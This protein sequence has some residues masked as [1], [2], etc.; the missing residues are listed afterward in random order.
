MSRALHGLAEVCVRWRW[1]V[2]GVWALI[3]VAHLVVS[4]VTGGPATDDDLSLPGTDSQ[5]ATD[6]LAAK[7]PPQQNGSSPVVFHVAAGRLDDQGANE[8][9]IKAGRKAVLALPSVYSAPNPFKNEKQAGYVS[10]DGRYVF[11]PVLLKESSGSISDELAQRV[12]AAASTPAVDQGIDVAVGGPVGSTLSTPSTEKSE[13]LGL[14][15]AMLIMAVTFG[16]LVAMGM[17][18]IS[19][20]CGLV[21]GLAL[22]GLLAQLTSVPSVGPTIATMIGLGVGIDYALFLVTKHRALLRDGLDVRESIVRA[23]ATSGGAVVF[24]GGTVV[25]ALVSLMVAGIPFVSAL[26]W[27][28]ALAVVTAVLAAIT[29]LPAVL[30]I[31]GNGINRLRLPWVRSTPK[32]TDGSGG[33]QRWARFVTG[34]PLISVIIAVAVLVPLILPVFTLRLGQE[35]IGVT[36]LSTTERQAFDLLSAGFGPG[37][38]GPLLVAVS[39]RPAAQQSAK[40]TKEYNRATKLQN[41]LKAEQKSL[42]TQSDEL[43]A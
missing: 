29:L 9:S 10:S 15:A 27:S 5:A 34:H 12:F 37:Y 25:I 7:F 18:I 4:S 36:P 39:L 21:A 43:K 26:G 42:T 1:L 30:A 41:Q 20:V 19:A 22:I 38:N 6:L 32:A 28:A 24:A 13:V 17:P 2:V 3:V 35:D 8:A 16:G 14:L 40:Y 31:V 33:W 23:V 11:I